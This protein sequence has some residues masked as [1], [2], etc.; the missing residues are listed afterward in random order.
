MQAD[1]KLKL[2]GKDPRFFLFLIQINQKNYFYLNFKIHYFFR[3]K[4]FSQA[5]KKIYNEGGIRGLWRGSIVNVQRAALVNLGGE[6]KL[7]KN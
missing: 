7:F 5:L 1:G 3:I 2:E 6:L 4:N